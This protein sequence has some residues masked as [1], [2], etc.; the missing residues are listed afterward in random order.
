MN[1]NQS[2]KLIGQFV[3]DLV[4]LDSG[5]FFLKT[6]IG[7]YEFPSLSLSKTSFFDRFCQVDDAEIA[8]DQ[9]IIDVRKDDL[10]GDIMILLGNKGIVSF[11][12]AFDPNSGISSRNLSVEDSDEA[13]DWITE[14][15]SYTPFYS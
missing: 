11:F 1:I 13:N 7:F 3:R 8:I 10:E 12:H 6:D 5:R 14:F 4:Y 15:Y 2:P 9:Q